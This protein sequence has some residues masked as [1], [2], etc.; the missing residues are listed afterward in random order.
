MTRPAASLAIRAD[1]DARIG[2]G[3]VMRCAA[4]AHA[5]LDA[6][7]RVIWISRTPQSIPARLA[8]RIDIRSMA[9][10]TVEADSLVPALAALR[11]NGLI[12]DWQTT[13]P[14][15][16]RQLRQSGIWLALIGNHLGGAE[17]DLL[18][19]QGFAQTPAGDAAGI[20]SGSAHILLPPGYAGLPARTIK[21]QVK[22]LL[23]SL[24][25]SETAILDRVLGALAGM[26]RLANVDL[27]I[28]RAAPRATALPECGLLDALCAADLGILAAGTTLHEAAAT[29]LA[30]IA[31]PIAANQNGRARQYQ[32][33]GLGLS[34][35]PAEPGFE[36]RLQEI[37]GDLLDAADRRQSFSAAGQ[38]SVDGEGAAR[39][40]ARIDAMISRVPAQ[41][42]A[43][44]STAIAGPPS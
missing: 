29:G 25:G 7:H 4:L 14:D 21:A 9:P 23:I 31:L 8:A 18:V 17:A 34:L 13:D 41:P 26:P 32:A 2:L 39:V 30:A 44:H 6:G 10:D 33:L 3:H 40:A 43:S 15:L 19:H 27:D 12:G 38:A 35:D 16:C 1:G 24:G 20:C 28:R 22:R 11:V 42:D 5:L 37:L 36:T